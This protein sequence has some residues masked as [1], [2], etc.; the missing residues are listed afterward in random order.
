[1]KSAALAAVREHQFTKLAYPSS[2]P[3]VPTVPGTVL[4]VPEAQINDILNI[5]NELF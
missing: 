3:L 5:K 2:L 4:K 1:M